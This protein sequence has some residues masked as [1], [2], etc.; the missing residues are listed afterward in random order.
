MDTATKRKIT[1]VFSACPQVV[2]AYFFGS[3][4]RGDA[5][6]M[7]DYDFAVQ[8]DKLSSLERS[9]LKLKLLADLS[10]ILKVD[11]VDL[12]ILNDAISPELKYAAIAEGE[13]IFEREPFRVLTEPKILN[14]YFD[15]RKIL[16]RHGLTKKVYV[17]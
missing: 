4:A 3:R 13:I 1:E 16:L 8:F 11:A 5:G 9:D 10:Y 15:F 6:P 17:E 7:S 14:E 2:V 12:V